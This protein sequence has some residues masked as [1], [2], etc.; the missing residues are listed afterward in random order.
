MRIKD[1]YKDD[2][3]RE[4]L[5]KF[6]PAKLSD[7][8]LLMAVIGSGN[9]QAGV[10]Q[11]AR[12]VLK[13]IKTQGADIDYV[14]LREVTGLGEAKIAVLLANFELARRYLLNDE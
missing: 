7:L 6:G 3:P 14:T 11:I 12:S 10:E 4:K 8:E 2:Q 13:L 1:R 9:A 5:A